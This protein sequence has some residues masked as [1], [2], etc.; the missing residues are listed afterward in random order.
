[1]AADQVDVAGLSVMLAE[2]IERVVEAL[3]LDVRSRTPRK[4]TCRSPFAPDKAKLEVEIYPIAGKWNDWIT[5]RFSDALDLV[6][7]ARGFED[8]KTREARRQSILWARDYFGLG[9]AGF[10]HDGW[11]RR[12][13]EAQ[14]RQAERRAKAQRELTAKR[15]TALGHWLHAKPIEP[16]DVGWRYLEARGIDLRQL[17]RRPGFLRVAERQDWFDDDGVVQHVG[18]AL[19]SAMTMAKTFGSLH[20]TWIDPARPGE[21]ADVPSPRKMWPD[22]EGCAIAIWRGESRMSDAEAAAKNHIEDLVLCEGVEDGLSIALMTP[23]LRVKACG[24]LPGLLSFTPAKNIRGITIAADNDWNK[25][26]AEQ[27]LKRACLRLRNDFGKA[28]RI[29]RSPEGKDFNDLLRERA[30]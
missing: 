9:A 24:S 2:D 15:K 30:E 6:A 19:M 10:D 23:E 29:A 11:I 20:R 28:V 26:Q 25:P 22:S 1:M 14:R 17:G 8:P 18:P 5:G 27:L 21:K 12:R 4:L 13:E 3:N 16:G 7:Y